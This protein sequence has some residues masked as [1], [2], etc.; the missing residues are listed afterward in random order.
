MSINILSRKD[1]QAARIGQYFTGKPCRYGHVAN[2]Y[3][4]SGA[5]AACVAVAAAKKRGVQHDGV[6][7]TREQLEQERERKLTSMVAARNEKTEALNKLVEIKLQI[8]P[9]DTNTIFET[10]VG[11]CIASSP[12][13]TR[14]DVLPSSTPIKGL[15]IYKVMVPLEYVDLM[16]Q[17]ANELWNAHSGFDP[18]AFQRNLIS[19]V[20]KMANDEASPAPEGFK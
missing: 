20:E 7:L 18:E 15:P 16:R 10:A 3:T 19:K 13:I 11:L 12:H 14:M 9:Q 17:T 5:C 8:M 6:V 4:Q 1:A 2:R